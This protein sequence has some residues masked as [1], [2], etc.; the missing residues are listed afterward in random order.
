M[1]KI[2]A[3]FLVLVM[4]MAFSG[5]GTAEQ[6]PSEPVKTESS[7][8]Q[9]RVP[10]NTP[11]TSSE[12]SKKGFTPLAPDG[13]NESDEAQKIYGDAEQEPTEASK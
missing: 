4:V 8:V 11:I 3:I 2:I 13:W 6:A 9:T 10:K 7:A 5:C 1:K 12:T